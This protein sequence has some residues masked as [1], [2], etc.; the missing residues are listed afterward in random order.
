MKTYIPLLIAVLVVYYFPARSYATD[1]LNMLEEWLQEEWGAVEAIALYPEDTRNAILEAAM[2][3]ELIVKVASLQARSSAIFTELLSGCPQEDQEGI[4]DLVRFPGLV[5]KLVEGDIKTKSQIKRILEDYPAKIHEMALKYGREEYNLLAEVHELDK[6]TEQTFEMMIA[7]YPKPAQKNFYKLI[8]HPEVMTILNENMSFTVLL[9]AAYREDPDA[10]KKRAVE[11]NLELA[12]ARA[13]AMRNL[14]EEVNP[15]EAEER[16]E[17][18]NAYAERYGY[19]ASH[20]DGPESDTDVNVTYYNHPYPY[21]FGYPNGYGSPHWHASLNWYIT[22]SLYTSVSLYTS[23]FLS[24]FYAPY[25]WSRVRV[26]P[27]VK[28]VSTS[29]RRRTIR[30]R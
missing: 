7:G 16:K 30:R 12:R 15:E 17:V 14:A 24:R 13:T 21:W 5:E 25:H 27:S 23:A 29:K 26:A 10:V 19:D 6:A 9:G 3:P 1:D 28:I 20:F 8:H 4:W 22:P 11:L 2:Y 18:A